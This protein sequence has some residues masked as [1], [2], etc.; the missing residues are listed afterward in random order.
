[1]QESRRDARKLRGQSYIQQEDVQAEGSVKSSR[2]SWRGMKLLNANLRWR[3]NPPENL[4]PVPSFKT[5]KGHV[6]HNLEPD[7][8][9][10]TDVLYK[11]WRQS[12]KHAGRSIATLDRMIILEEEAEERRRLEEEEKRLRKKP[13]RRASTKINLSVDFLDDTRNNNTE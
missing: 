1:M 6:L 5:K 13:I 3:P 12:Q 9:H 4:P 2:R 11:K 7:S 10:F 8:M